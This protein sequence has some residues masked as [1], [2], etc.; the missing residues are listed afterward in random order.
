MPKP[1]YRSLSTLVAHMRLP[2]RLLLLFVLHRLSCVPPQ[3]TRNRKEERRKLLHPHHPNQSFLVRIVH[4]NILRLISALQRTAIA[5]TVVTEVIGPGCQ[6]APPTPY[7][8]EF[9]I[10]LGIM[11]N[12]AGQRRVQHTVV[13]QATVIPNLLLT[14]LRP[15]RSP[16]VVVLKPVAGHPT[17][18][19]F[20]F[21]MAMLHPG[22]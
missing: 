19:V 6:N 20:N 4:G 8:V 16:T 13:H 2:S 1:L 18:F 9:A 21:L 11:T 22:L 14:G 7:S 3:L 15:Q 5:R 12:A 17:L 10:V